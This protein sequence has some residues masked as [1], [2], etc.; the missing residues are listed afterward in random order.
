MTAL[1]DSTTLLMD[2]TLARDGRLSIQLASGEVR[3]TATDADRIVIRTPDGEGVRG[4]LVLDGDE[5][6]VTVRERDV[7]GISFGRHRT[8]IRLEV[9]TPRTIEATVDVASGE[10]AADGVRR[11]QR[12]RTASADVRVTDAAGDV[13]VNAVS[14]DVDLHLAGAA[15]VDVRTVSGDVTLDGGSLDRVRIATTSGDIRVDSPLTGTAGNAIET[16][17]GDVS[18]AAS[19]GIRVEA[20]TVSGD[21]AS[22]LPH[23]TEGRAGRRALVVGDGRTQLSFRSVSGDLMIR[24]GPVDGPRFAGTVARP[25]ARGETLRPPTPPA[26]GAPAPVDPPRPPEQPVDASAA[27]AARTIDAERLAVLRALERGDLDLATAMDRLA[28]LDDRE[29]AVAVGGGETPSATDRTDGGD[30]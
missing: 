5:T 8:A 9:T 30:V 25:P 15:S 13:D 27:S 1:H 26:P 19:E 2:Q 11:V 21:L 17:S 6:H 14:G 20:R 22:D 4:R 7:A 16:L 10:I 28:E 23:R 24:R 29:A 3:L 12:Y 18:I